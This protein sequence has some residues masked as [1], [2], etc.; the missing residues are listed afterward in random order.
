[1]PK[2]PEARGIVVWGMWTIFWC[3]IDT[4]LF[5]HQHSGTLGYMGV[6]GLSTM[7]LGISAVG[8]TPGRCASR[9]GSRSRGGF[10]L[11]IGKCLTFIFLCPVPGV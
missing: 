10:N 2:P 8:V 11:S 5:C 6:P 9:S 7:F 4:L 3:N 1:M